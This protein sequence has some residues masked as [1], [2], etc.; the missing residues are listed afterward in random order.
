M[1]RL[2]LERMSP[3]LLSETLPELLSRASREMVEL[4]LLDHRCDVNASLMS[5]LAFRRALIEDKLSGLA[6]LDWLIE[7]D[8]P[9]A[10]RAAVALLEPTN[11]GFECCYQRAYYGY[12]LYMLG[13]DCNLSDLA[14]RLIRS[15][16]S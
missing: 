3:M 16:H 12:F 4:I 13:R 6:S 9:E 15:R 7:N 14:W 11:E 10:R 1:V 8:V 5:Y 2:L